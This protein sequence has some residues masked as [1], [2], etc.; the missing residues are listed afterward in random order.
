M[1]QVTLSSWLKVGKLGR[2]CSSHVIAIAQKKAD[3]L[4]SVQVKLLPTMIYSAP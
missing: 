2:Q 1:R 4:L 3:K